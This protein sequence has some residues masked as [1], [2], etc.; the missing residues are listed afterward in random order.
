MEE[1]LKLMLGARGRGL[2][3]LLSCVSSGELGAVCSTCKP[4]RNRRLNNF[5]AIM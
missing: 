3:L 1:L 5:P 2:Q 4:R